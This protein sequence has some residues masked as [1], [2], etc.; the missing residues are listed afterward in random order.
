MLQN[1]FLFLLFFMRFFHVM[2]S[3]S[4]SCGKVLQDSVVTKI[5]SALLCAWSSTSSTT[6][7]N[8]D[9]RYALCCHLVDASVDTA[10]VFNY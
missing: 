10:L 2:D 9:D 3:Y 5:R 4:S 6:T 8:V 1:T 7:Q